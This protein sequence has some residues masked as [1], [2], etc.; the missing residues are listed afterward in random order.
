MLNRL[1]G[2][3]IRAGEDLQLRFLAAL[4]GEKLVL[5]IVSAEGRRRATL[6]VPEMWH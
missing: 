5:P 4:P 3:P 1:D 6:I 2:M